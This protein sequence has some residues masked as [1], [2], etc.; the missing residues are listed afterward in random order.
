[1]VPFACN[2]QDNWWEHLGIEEDTIRKPLDMK[3]LDL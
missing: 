1:M 3:F 2:F